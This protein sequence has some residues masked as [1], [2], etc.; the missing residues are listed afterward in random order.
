MDAL[1]TRTHG[2]AAPLKAEHVEG[3]SRAAES[4]H[5]RTTRRNYEGGMG[6]VR[7]MV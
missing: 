2:K 4:A 1:I 7:R 6:P 5:A 3:I